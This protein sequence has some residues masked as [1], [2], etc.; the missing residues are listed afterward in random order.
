MDPVAQAQEHVEQ[1]QQP[2]AQKEQQQ[3]Q[4]QRTNFDCLFHTPLVINTSD[5]NLDIPTTNVVVAAPEPQG[6]MDATL[7]TDI[8]PVQVVAAGQTSDDSG[9]CCCCGDDDDDGD[10]CIIM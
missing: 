6:I 3:Q 5:D 10:C 1:Q 2:Q 8:K 4:Q 9:D 7:S